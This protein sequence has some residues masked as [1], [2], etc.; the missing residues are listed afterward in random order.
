[1]EKLIPDEPR[2]TWFYAW[3][4]Y[5]LDVGSLIGKSDIILANLDEN[6]DP[7]VIVEMMFAKQMGKAVIGYRTDMRAVFGKMEDF[8][9]GMHFFCFFPCDYFVLVPSYYSLGIKNRSD[10]ESFMNSII[11]E[12][13]KAIRHVKEK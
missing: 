4:I 7:G 10:S 5:L 6:M 8:C 1:M 12:L 9:N 3:A 11:I 13:D 2:R